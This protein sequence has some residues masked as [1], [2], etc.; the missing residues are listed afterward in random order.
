MAE[1][2]GDIQINGKWYRIDLESYRARDIIDFSPRA[3]SPGGGI[4]LSDLMLY[5]PLMQTD[6]RHGFGFPA[7]DDVSGY[8]S[9]DGHIDTRH[10]GLAMMSTRPIC[11]TSTEWGDDLF[12]ITGGLIHNGE[13]YFWGPQGCRKFYTTIEADGSTTENWD[14]VYVNTP[15]RA[16]NTML[17]LGEAL[18]ACPNGT[19]IRTTV[20]DGKLKLQPGEYGGAVD[21]WIEQN[22][23]DK[24][25]ANENT[26]VVGTTN[27]SETA[28]IYIKFDLS[29]VP[30]GATVTSAKLTFMVADRT[31]EV[32]KLYISQCA[33]SNVSEMEATWNIFKAGSS[34]TTAGAK[35]EEDDR[36]DHSLKSNTGTPYLNSSDDA[37]ITITATARQFFTIELDESQVQDMCTTNNGMLIWGDY[38]GL[39]LRNLKL[40]S[41]KEANSDWRPCLTVEYTTAE[42]WTNTGVDVDAKD[43]K[44]AVIHNGFTYLGVDG[45]N[46][47]HYSS[48][49]TLSDVEGSEDDPSH[50]LIGAGNRPTIGAISFLSNLYIARSDGLWQLGDDKIARRTLDFSSEESDN[51]FKSMCVFNGY[52]IFPIK[53]TIYQWNGARLT[54]ITPQ[55]IDNVWPFI[56]YGDFKNFIT[57]G[58]F[59][60]C[61]GRT[62]E[63]RYK[64]ALLC[65]DG[66][67]WHKIADLINTGWGTITFLYYD[68]INNRMWYH[69]NGVYN[70]TYY[71]KFQSQSDYPYPYFELPTDT[72]FP[73]LEKATTSTNPAGRF[74]SEVSTNCLY[75]CLFDMGFARITKSTPSLLVEAENLTKK[76]FISVNYSIDGGR[77][78]EWGRIFENGITELTWPGGLRTQEFK[79]IQLRF[80]FY[81]Y[82]R[83]QSPILKGYTLRFLMRP[84][85]AYGWNFNIVAADHFV[86]GEREDERTAATIIE[87]IKI[88]R[89]SKAPISFVD[90]QGTEHFAYVSSYSESAQE[91]NVDEENGG[92]PSI[93]S[94]VNV[95]IVEA[96]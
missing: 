40:C 5:Q 31:E 80:D 77:W 74:G 14:A 10:E 69:Y 42:E 64:E 62:N 28:A 29:K 24:N 60:Y 88:A 63:T 1:G 59:M 89:D 11:K 44:W 94:V 57:V 67:G 25:Y 12:R 41:S 23:P 66:V 68:T 47:V 39:Q 48:S 18:I 13:N 84:E 82:V 49:D 65:Y 75:T 8:F 83:A 4:I 32:P 38:T 21:T 52:L 93:E 72:V 19:R 35:H 91:R 96:K 58:D 16:I 61:T 9:S 56:S 36:L 70:S 15:A 90:I 22:N 54:K 34:W 51:N 73:E 85:V 81:T 27:T 20:Y 76:T 50:I 3:A 53:D 92:I 95:N 45:T 55:R 7:Y 46:R 26:L 43:F 17:S 37:K 6:W 78:V 2:I 79:Y 33:R 87:D 71:I 30:S 86:Y